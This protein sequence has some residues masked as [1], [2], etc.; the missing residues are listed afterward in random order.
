MIC[1][2]SKEAVLAAPVGALLLL[3]D[4]FTLVLG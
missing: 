1:G 2:G 3:D 4:K